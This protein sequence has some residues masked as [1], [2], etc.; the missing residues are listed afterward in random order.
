MI[1]IIAFII[2]N[3]CWF[4]W[5]YGA[6]RLD[7]FNWDEIHHGDY[8]WALVLVSCAVGSVSFFNIIGLIGLIFVI[9][10]TISHCKYNGKG[11]VLQ[12]ICNFLLN[13]FGTTFYKVWK[14]VS[15][16]K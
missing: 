1:E 11:F 8:G 6:S 12:K 5:R 4:I 16:K 14:W 15:G 7:N 9:D 13:I 10:D 3:I 2:A